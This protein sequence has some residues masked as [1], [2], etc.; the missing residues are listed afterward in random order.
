MLN[1]TADLYD[2]HPEQVQVATSGFCDYGG[3]YAFWGTIATVQC[4][5]DNSLVRSSLEQPGQKRVLVVDGG[6]SVR[7]ALLGDQLARIAHTNGWSG[8]IINGCIRDSEIIKTIDI[9]IKAVGTC[10]S[11]IHI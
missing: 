6:R 1:T 5:E 3:V 9:G 4:F 10:L 2:R 8:L 11:L 7:C